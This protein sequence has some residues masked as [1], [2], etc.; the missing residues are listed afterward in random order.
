MSYLEPAAESDPRVARMY[1]HDVEV[2]GY[3]ANYT[4]TFAH[5]P[6]VY[7]AWERLSASIKFEM[8]LHRYEVATVAAARTLRS[9]YCA[10]AHGKI[11]AT[12]LTADAVEALA[13]GDLSQ[14]GAEDAAIARLAAR[15]AESGPD[16]GVEHLT[17]LR[18]LG[19]SEAEIFDVIV[20]AAARCFFS[21]AL[22]ASGTEPDAAL[23]D[24]EESLR[25]ALTVGRPIEPPKRN[26]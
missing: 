16:V 18:D 6:A 5:R 11:L 26:A 15:V 24:Q 17:E 19:F 3:V 21:T 20:A 10:L 14:L 13:R 4:R 2:L 25:E 22:D 8:P 1:A 23:G 9:S 12:D 7:A